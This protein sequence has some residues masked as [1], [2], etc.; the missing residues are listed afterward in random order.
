M[1]RNRAKSMAVMIGCGK[2]ETLKQSSTRSSSNLSK[3]VRSLRTRLVSSSIRPLPLVGQYFPDELR[4]GLA[5]PLRLLGL[6]FSIAPAFI[7]LSPS[8]SGGLLRRRKLFQPA[9]RSID[10]SA[11][12]T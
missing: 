10:F 11:H 4:N 2:I 8:L 3:A 1:E 9:R 5:W 12:R 7:F 6:V